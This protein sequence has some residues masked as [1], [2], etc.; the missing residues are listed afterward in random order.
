MMWL[1]VKHG[2]VHSIFSSMESHIAASLQFY[3][4]ITVMKQPGPQQQG[5]I[6]FFFITLPT[7]TPCGG[8]GSQQRI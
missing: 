4:A 7:Q 5:E 1:S 2:A 3:P 8:E 6:G